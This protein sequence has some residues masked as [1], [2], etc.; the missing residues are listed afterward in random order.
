MKILIEGVLGHGN[1]TS[2]AVFEI[3]M[4][5]GYC[6]GKWVSFS[7]YQSMHLFLKSPVARGNWINRKGRVFYKLHS[8]VHFEFCIIWMLYD[9]S[10]SLA[11]EGS[12]RV[13]LDWLGWWKK[14]RWSDCNLSC[15]LKL[16]IFHIPINDFQLSVNSA[17]CNICQKGSILF[18]SILPPFLTLL[19]SSLT[20]HC[21]VLTITIFT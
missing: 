3:K 6:I 10:L 20:P 9:V 19:H 2:I 18:T 13:C 8:V 15:C 5:T 12:L 21:S 1:T 17:F 14:S 4:T 11:E 16:N 7:L